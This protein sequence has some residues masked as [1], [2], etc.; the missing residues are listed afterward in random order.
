M[1]VACKG[2]GRGG[3]LVYANH[4]KKQFYIIRNFKLKNFSMNMKNILSLTHC[5]GK[6]HKR[7]YS[8]LHSG[9]SSIV[10]SYSNPFEIRSII[11]KENK[12]KAGISRW[13]NLITGEYYIGSSSNLGKR[14][15]NYFSNS[16]F[17]RETKRT[18]SAIYASLLKNG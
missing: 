17:L 14:F 3:M 16:F 13:I 8:S 1:I 5:K 11:Y 2:S 10:A 15:S 9:N 4:N 6:W 7:L 12:S 18:K